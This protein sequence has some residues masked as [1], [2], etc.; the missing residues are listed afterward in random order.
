MCLTI[1][2]QIVVVDRADPVAPTAI[3]DYSGE[4]R[5]VSLL[6][7]PDASVG[8]YVV[9]HAGFATTRLPETEALEALRYARE[10]AP[11]RGGT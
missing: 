10:M 8:E 2:G 1:P 5:T 3:V 11:T 6:Y 7:V 9:V 4:R